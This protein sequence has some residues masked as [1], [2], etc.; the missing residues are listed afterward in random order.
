MVAEKVQEADKNTILDIGILV[1]NQF[2]PQFPD[3]EVGSRLRTEVSLDVDFYH[4]APLVYSWRVT[5][6]LMQTAPFIEIASRSGPFG[7]KVW[8]RDLSKSNYV[9]IL[10]T[11]AWKDDHGRGDYIL[12]CELLRPA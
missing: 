1:Y 3:V 9:E 8:T 5:S 4:S 6:I 12:R 11:D 10:K 7:G 2:G